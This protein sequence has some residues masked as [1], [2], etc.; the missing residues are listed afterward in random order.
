MGVI[1]TVQRQRE[2]NQEFKTILGDMVSS[3]IT[4]ATWDPVSKRGPIPER[5]IT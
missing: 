1:P 3:R 2:K 5:L 4:W